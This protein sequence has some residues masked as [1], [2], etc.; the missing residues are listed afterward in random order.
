MK[1]PNC[2]Y[3]MTL[4]GELKNQVVYECAPCYKTI[5]RKKDDVEKPIRFAFDTSGLKSR[6]K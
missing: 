1:C 5:T 4:K 3:E 2:R 6:G